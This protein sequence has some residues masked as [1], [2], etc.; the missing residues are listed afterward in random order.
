MH[1]MRIPSTGV[2][3]VDRDAARRGARAAGVSRGGVRLLEDRHRRDG[4]RPDAAERVRHVHHPQAARRVA[5]PAR[6]Q[7]R[8]ARA[9]RRGARPQ[10][11]GNNYEFT[12]PIQ[13]R[14]NELI[15]GVRGDVAVKVYGDDFDEMQPAADADRR[16]ARSRARRR[17]REGRADRGRCRCM[18][19]DDR[20]R[21]HRPLR[22]ERRRR[23]GRGRRSR[24]AGA[25]PG[26]CSRATAAS[27][28]S[29]ACPKRLR[30]DL[31]GARELPIPLPHEDDAASAR[32]RSRG[33]DLRPRGRCGFVPLG[34]AWRRSRSRE[35]P[36][37]ISRENGKRRIVV[38]ANVRGRDLGSFVAEAQAQRR[39][40][41]KL[42][43]GSWLD[44]GGQFENLLAA[45][46][47]LDD[48]RAALLLP[49]LPAAVLRDLRLGAP[50]R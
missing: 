41:V 24:S 5:R 19:V 43:P 15:A 48:R 31:D 27:T 18:N 28:W 6:H 44:W 35:G 12:Q 17:R 1:A 20:P 32:R 26:W 10:L 40:E 25:R 3:A 11:P 2:D 4:L 16:G 46:Q 8:R 29:C 45:R 13:M 49:D 37:Q 21:R 14:F 23:A 42:P 33:D 9:H 38:Q 50:T 30:R 22:P 39:R 36:N 47:R 34:V 7:G